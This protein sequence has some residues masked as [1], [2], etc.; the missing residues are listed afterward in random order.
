MM[1]FALHKLALDNNSLL[2]DL[3]Y[4]HGRYYF[5]LYK[6]TDGLASLQENEALPGIISISDYL[7]AHLPGFKSEGFHQD[8]K[9]HVD[10]GGHFE[11]S[12]YH[13]L[14][15]QLDEIISSVRPAGVKQQIEI[16]MVIRSGNNVGIIEAKTGANKAGIDQLDTAGNPIYLGEHTIKF[17][18][19]GRYL[20]PAYKALALAQK[21]H[22][23][24]LPGYSQGRGLGNK[25]KRHLVQTVGTTL[26][27]QRQW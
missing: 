19:T 14:K 8:K 16:D 7:N 9:G 2:A 22:V 17:L 18:V 24:E 15:K 27:S 11:A 12:I 26:T 6:F 3:E 25:D 20:S 21:I 13:A 10:A 5:R 23:V 4:I 1:A